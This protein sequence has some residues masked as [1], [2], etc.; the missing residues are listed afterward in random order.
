MRCISLILI[1]LISL[2]SQAAIWYVDINNNNLIRNGT[3]WNTAVRAFELIEDE[4]QDGDQV[5]FAAGVY[6][7]NEPTDIFFPNSSGFRYARLN[8]KSNVEMYGG[9]VGDEN[10]LNQRD[11][12]ANPTILRVTGWPDINHILVSE[13]K[14]AFLDGFIWED[15]NGVSDFF[16]AFTL[17]SSGAECTFSN[18]TFRDFQTNQALF[19]GGI[20]EDLDVLAELNFINC[21]L[22]DIECPTFTELDIVETFDRCEL[23]DMVGNTENG[24]LFRGA[25]FRRSIFEDNQSFRFANGCNFY[26]CLLSNNLLVPGGSAHAFGD[27]TMVNCTIVDNLVSRG[28]WDCIITNCIFTDNN[29]TFSNFISSQSCNV[30]FSILEDPHTGAGG[31][32]RVI[33]PEFINPPSNYRLAACSPAINGGGGT[34]IDPTDL[35]DN[36]RINDGIVDIGCYEY[37][38]GFPDRIYVDANATGADNGTSWPNA[39]TDLQDALSNT[40]PRT[41]IWVANGSY[42]PT[43]SFDRFVSFELPEGVELYGGFAGGE[44]NVNQRDWENNLT[45]LSGDIGNNFVFDNSYN[46]LTIVGGTTPIETIVDGFMIAGGN[47]TG[48]SPDDQNGAGIKA[49]FPEAIV[50]NCIIQNNVASNDGA[51]IYVSGSGSITVEDCTFL[52]NQATDSGGGIMQQSVVGLTTD[53]TINRCRFQT[54]SAGQGG[55][56]YHVGEVLVTNSIFHDNSSPDGGDAIQISSSGDLEVHACTF[57]SNDELAIKNDGNYLMRNSILFSHLG[58]PIENNGTEEIAYCLAGA[59][60]PGTNNIAASPLFINAPGGNFNLQTISPA[61][62]AGDYTEIIGNGDYDQNSRVVGG[63]ID[64]GAIENPNGCSLPNDLC[65]GAIEFNSVEESQ[66]SLPLECASGFGEIAPSCGSTGKSVWIT[67]IKPE[68]ALEILLST[69]DQPDADLQATVYTGE[70]DA[71]VEI[72]CTNSGG[73]GAGEVVIISDIPEGENIFIAI[74]TLNGITADVQVKVSEID[75]NIL[76]YT[77]GGSGVCAGAGEPVFVQEVTVEY[78]AAPSS[79]MLRVNGFDFELTGSPQ[80]VTIEVPAD[81]NDHDVLISL[82]GGDCTLFDAEVIAGQCCQPTHDFCNFARPLL[83]GEQL[84]DQTR[85]STLSDWYEAPCIE[86]A[87]ID[88]WYVFQAPSDGSVIIRTNLVEVF[89]NAFNMRH[90]LFSGTCG[91]FEVVACGNE[92]G[93]GVDE[94]T[95]VT[96]LSP[97]EIYYLRVSGFN[98]QRARYT[99][100][101]NTDIP[102]PADLDESGFIN[103]NDLLI[104]LSQ[105][106]CEENCSADLDINGTVSSSDLLVFLTFFG[107]PCP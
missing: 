2:S 53:V 43:A 79:A 68:S 44:N 101:V 78:E 21:Q 17:L 64:I 52:N 67:S 95:I 11:P 80:L 42:K 30:N 77:L 99:V 55:A 22:D 76:G 105:F 74:A 16:S 107:N 8:I 72:S 18:S 51:G 10:A 73:S 62:N 29:S 34:G 57:Y 82:I 1:S 5:W 92:F 49:V 45:V 98:N 59:A 19:K 3:S 85:C 9:F 6:V 103:S 89:T 88:N 86:T 24:R 31:Q 35:D 66:F 84:E 87:G 33:D 4:V 60:L 40:C 50:R 63:Q 54:N 36:P 41:E 56:L 100:E 48:S 23:T 25:T 96:G 38:G 81:G 102:C 12:I 32:N 28:F 97:G 83:V 20:N 26:N 13:N 104:L 65:D 69:E 93:D 90:T 47:A 75:C 70:C 91:D 61:I 71:L 14:T 58:F 15:Y 27:C 94:E 7:G 37:Q 39:Y 106:G 46:I